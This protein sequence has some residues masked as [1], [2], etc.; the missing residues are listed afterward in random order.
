M[1]VSV[2]SKFDLGREEQTRRIVRALSHKSVDVLAH[3]T[4]RIIG[5]R[6]GIAIDFEAVCRAAR[7]HGVVLE[8]NA[9]PSRLDLDDVT[10]RAAVGAGL[11]LQI[12]TD[13][14]S[15]AELRFMRWGVDQAR[16]GWVDASNVLNT[17]KLGAL[18]KRLHGRG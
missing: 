8:I 1:L 10:A 16:R 13:A 3:P 4:G 14:H 9:Q 11:Q 5:G 17:L 2:H 18:L 12:A 7:D 15:T 6:R